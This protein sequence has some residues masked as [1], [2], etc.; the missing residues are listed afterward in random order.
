[1]LNKSIARSMPE[2]EALIHEIR[3]QK[4]M[5]D[6]D[7]ARIYG[8]P[9]KAFNQAV[10]RNTDKFSADF[11]FRLAAK[12]A[13]EFQHSRSQIVTASRR[14]IRAAHS[15]LPST[16]P[17]WRPTS[18]PPRFADEYDARGRRRMD[19]IGRMVMRPS[20]SGEREPTFSSCERFS[21]CA[22]C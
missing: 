16:A 6:S 11:M 12:K 22:H 4:V 20:V 1:V 14:N 19:C 21:K 8:L 17:S 3:G 9:T 7:L 5:L 2:L 13:R 18:L 10:K 15:S